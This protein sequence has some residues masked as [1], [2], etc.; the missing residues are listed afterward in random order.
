MPPL[1][2]RRLLAATGGTLAIGGV[3]G[4]SGSVAADRSESSAEPGDDWSSRRGSPGNNAYFPNRSGPETPVAVA[5]EYD[6]GGPIAV[7]EG[8]VY[9]TTDG[10]IHALDATDGSVGWRSEDVGASGTPAVADG[11]VYVGGDALVALDA[12]DGT[13]RWE[14]ELDGDDVAPPNV[15]SGTIVTCVGATVSAFDTDGEEQ[16]A[17][18][19]EEELLRASE[20]AVADGAVF[21][22]S[23]SH[24]FARELEDGSERWTN[25]RPEDAERFVLHDP[26][27]AVDGFVAVAFDDGEGPYADDVVLY[28]TTTGEEGERYGGA[29]PATIGE[30]RVYTNP[31]YDAAGYDRE[32]GETVW[33]PDQDIKHAQQPVV[34]AD[35]VYAGI[36]A[37]EEMSG[38]DGEHGLYAF[39]SA[40]DVAWSVTP[41][42]VLELNATLV[43]GTVYGWDTDRLLAVR[44]EADLG[45]REDD[46]DD[47]TG[48]ADDEDDETSGD[49]EADDE[50]ENT[51]TESEET[52]GDE[53]TSTDDDAE[54]GGDEEQDDGETGADDTAEGAN[55]ADGDDEAV[56]GFTTGAGVAG[57]VLGLEWLRR[58]ANGDG[59]TFADPD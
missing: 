31:T 2:R 59:E 32:T 25:E 17:F 10:A 12:E 33:E 54:D 14:R 28:D 19:A 5:W 52:D 27:V 37:L 30:D 16:W 56:P 34:G 38:G 36:N 58:R 48:E 8:A 49:G 3:L 42:D 39:D 13:V 24:V 4:S 57:G 9:L 23:A 6:A 53:P 7:Q 35:R 43:E 40:G 44:S 1:T 18:E 50:E 29:T 21:A 41:D 15:A 20:T 45:E 11:S 51:E 22:C 26:I 55:G 47:E 46:E